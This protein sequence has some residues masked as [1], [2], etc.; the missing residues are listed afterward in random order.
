MD[1]LR[2]LISRPDRIGDVVL[3]TPIPREIKK[4][5][6]DSFV[7]VLLRPYTKDI[8]LNNPYVD[9]II[10]YN[11]SDIHSSFW[12]KV[13]EI[14]EY[15]FTHS[16]MLLPTERINY[17]LFFAGIRYRIGV[18]HKFYQFITNTK[19]VYRNKYIPL[20]HESEYCLDSIRKIGI[21]VKD[22]NPEIYLTDSEKENSCKSKAEILNNS[23]YLVGIHITSGNSAPNWLPQMYLEL[24]KVILKNKSIQPVIT[25]NTLPGEL[26]NLP[27]VIYP[28]KGKNLRESI[29]N[30]SMLDLLI[31]ASTGPMH[32]AAAL[33]VKTLSLFCPMTACSPE[34]WG[35]RGN[36]NS[37]LTPEKDYCSQKCP[38]DPK[39]CVFSDGGITIEQV[40][41]E[42][43]R[44]LEE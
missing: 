40:S 7:A 25:D 28:N 35:P 9:E 38:G 36:V 37:I 15:N 24:L 12:D 17:M 41:N 13:K 14:R 21:E 23:K 6:P 8:Y 2:I 19:S 42:I 43:G 44:I 33:K 11:E 1:N 27:G 4:Q 31:S 29:I 39:K 5:N 30:F 18:G 16:I 26:D 22:S 34:L 32:L 20:R 10:L 3:S